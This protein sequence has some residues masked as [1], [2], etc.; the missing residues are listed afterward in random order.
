MASFCITCTILKELE[1][2]KPD[3]CLFVGHQLAKKEV[4]EYLSALS[5]I[6]KVQLVIR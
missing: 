4:V 6:A 5:R 3:N 2:L 1:Q